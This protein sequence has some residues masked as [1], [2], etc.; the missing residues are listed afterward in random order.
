[1]AW[2][3][4][5]DLNQGLI[6]EAVNCDIRQ[7]D[8]AKADPKDAAS[9]LPAGLGIRNERNHR[10]LLMISLIRMPRVS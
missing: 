8:T 9:R 4:M 5:G 3:A 2:K 10:D 1:M 7:N 6:L